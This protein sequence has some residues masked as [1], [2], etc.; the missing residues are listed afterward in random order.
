MPGNHH[1]LRLLD[2]YAANVLLLVHSGDRKLVAMLRRDFEA[3]REHQKAD[4]PAA[5]PHLIELLLAHEALVI[6]ADGGAPRPTLDDIHSGHQSA[7][8]RLRALA[9]A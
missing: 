7:L 4:L 5:G 9:A 6:A 3:I 2:V 8:A 1:F